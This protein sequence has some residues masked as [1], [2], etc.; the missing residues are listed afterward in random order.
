MK[1]LKITVEGKTYEVVVEI[2]DEVKSAGPAPMRVVSASP[3]SAPVSAAAKPAATAQAAGPGDVISPLTGKIAAIAVEVGAEV[4]E[5]DPIIT[6]EAM[7]MN[8]YVNAT[9][10]GK[11]TAINIQVGDGVE[12]GQA[13]LRI[14]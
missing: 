9:K 13:L 7:K 14:E 10:T 3:V 2:P 6:V 5:G 4:K 1:K 11:V 8:T 12:E